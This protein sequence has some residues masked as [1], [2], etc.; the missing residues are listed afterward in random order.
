[1]T[2]RDPVERLAAQLFE[3]AREERPSRAARERALRSAE[4]GSMPVVSI[5][6]FASRPRGRARVSLRAAVAAL[7]IAA[8]AWIAAGLWLR[9]AHRDFFSISPEE[10]ESPS[11]NARRSVAA[12]DDRAR[13]RPPARPADVER[14][15]GRTKAPARVR[16]AEQVPAPVALA[17]EIAAIDRA[18]SALAS[19]DTARALA[20]LD[21]YERVLRGTRLRAEARLLRIEV[22]SKSGRSVEAAELAR[23]FVVEFPGSPLAERARA[24][25]NV[26]SE[27]EGVQR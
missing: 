23:R 20:L 11:S 9:P 19:A 22:L 6:A 25:S 24:L 17:D 14:A 1:M 5:G 27:H 15:G 16:S 4:R 2:E 8:A 13:A 10:A 7:G 3:A 26:Q 18:R 12:P 21:D